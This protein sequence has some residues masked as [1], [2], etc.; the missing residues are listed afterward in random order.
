MMNRSMKKQR[1]T[2]GR[3]LAQSPDHHVLDHVF[4]C[5][6]RPAAGN[7]KTHSRYRPWVSC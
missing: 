5:F 4:V 3:F 6:D 2:P 1:R 7:K